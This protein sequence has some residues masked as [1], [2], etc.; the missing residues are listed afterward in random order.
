MADADDLLRELAG[1]HGVATSFWGWGGALKEVS[2][3]TLRSV[4][5]ALGVPAGSPE[6]MRAAL[7]DA[8]LAA[9]R[10]ILPPT[11]V[12]R[13]GHDTTVLAH[14]PHGSAVSVWV[15]AE[16]GTEY[17]A[18]QVENWD[19]PRTVDGVLTGR[20]AFLLPEGLPLGWHTLH[21]QNEGGTAEATLVV[22]PDRLTTTDRLADRQRWGLMGQLYS[23][24]S[25]RSWGVGDFADLGDL[26]AIGAAEGASFVLVNPLHA[27][28]PAPPIEDSPYLPTT[29]RFVNPLYLRVEDI[30]DY[31][32]LTGEDRAEV[33]ALAGEFAASNASADLLDRNASYTAKLEAL[34]MIWR[35]PRSRARE[36]AYRRFC[37]G[38]G[39]GLD[40]FA[41]WCALA[42]RPDGPGL[43]EEAWPPPASARADLLREQLA[44]RIDFHRWLQ[45]V[46]DE[47]LD[48]AQRTARAAGM[49][50]GL[51]HD[52]AVGVRPDGADAWVLA[53]V[54]ARGVAVGAPPDMYNQQGQNWSQP[55][56]H[57]VRLAESGYAAYRDMLRTILRHAG[58]IRVDHVLGLFRLWWVPEGALP[59][60]G[61]YVHYDHEALVGILALE[62]QRA[63]AIVIGE[64]LGVFEP[65][66]RDYL[67]ERGIFGTSILWFE[68][69]GERPL[70]P[71]KYRQACLTSVNT[72]DLPPTAGYLAGEHVRLRET[73]GL[74]ER[75]VE[76]E[77][78]AAE[79]EI[80]G[81]LGLLRE[82]GLLPAEVSLADEQ[83]VIEALYELT[84]LTP[85]SLLGVALVDAV[86]DRRT[87]NQ[88]GTYLEHPNWRIPL[89]G[90]DGNG[91][92]LDDLHRNPRFASLL[93]VMRSA[94][95]G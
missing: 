32:Y 77:L 16:D 55:P 40:D 29:R 42:E 4:L 69:D 26:A 94:V 54:L 83:R 28:E 24:R 56:W 82:R 73:L 74:L 78:A 46:S 7:E 23:V 60:D 66:V 57:P 1:R 44:D 48:A 14:I 72:H 10:R 68:Y 21:A 67:A 62:A 35:V 18:L 30:P 81:V 11:T 58:G 33:E 36:D 45:W 91:I 43:H 19:E 53:D 52:L 49:E 92:L 27:A 25:S 95:D 75:S 79:A 64:D 47:Q 85:S 76:E 93:A 71:E 51:L 84:A 37:D 38:A 41:L 39:P 15:T 59:G 9:W 63:G 20:A 17:P 88:P 3:Q 90:A 89:T 70:P 22:T 8:D 13:E 12:A 86:G 2:P 87:Q 6:E 31:A 34:D 65:W 5:G 80:D 61:A 50:I